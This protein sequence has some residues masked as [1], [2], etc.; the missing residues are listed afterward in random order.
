M[1]Y[2]TFEGTSGKNMGN[3]GAFSENMGG[4]MGKMGNMGNMGNMLKVGSLYFIR[5]VSFKQ[6]LEIG[7]TSRI[8][9]IKIS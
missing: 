2:E 4:N 7:L 8:N 9:D 3:M 5:L 6:L 1:I